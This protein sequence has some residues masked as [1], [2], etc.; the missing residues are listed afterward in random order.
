MPETTPYISANLQRQDIDL[1]LRLAG[2]FR[3]EVLR[4]A[5]T[6]QLYRPDWWTDALS[7]EKTPSSSHCARQGWHTR[8]SLLPQYLAAGPVR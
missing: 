2:V 4:P 1:L 6:L 7:P 8:L 3:S 5:P